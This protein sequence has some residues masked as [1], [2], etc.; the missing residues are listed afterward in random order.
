M[1]EKYTKM[2]KSLVSNVK[3]V[4]YLSD[5]G[6][7]T[8][9]HSNL[10]HNDLSLMKESILQHIL[11]NSNYEEEIVILVPPVYFGDPKIFIALT[12]IA[13]FFTERVRMSSLSQE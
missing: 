12:Y 9:K 8:I 2:R 13:Q 6:I 7:E 1:S 3:L 10:Y 4:Q 5:N 11:D